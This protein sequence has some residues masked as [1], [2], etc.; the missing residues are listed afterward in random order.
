MIDYKTGTR[1]FTA[2]KT[3]KRYSKELKLQA[4]HAYLSGEGSLDEKNRRFSTLSWIRK[5]KK[6]LPE[7]GRK[8][9]T[10]EN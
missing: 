4:V 6:E 10:T 5:V 7:V 1:K 9:K 2:P 3:N 8:R